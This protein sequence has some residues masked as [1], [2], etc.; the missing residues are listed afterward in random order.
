[1]VRFA[2]EIPE[3]LNKEFRIR[4]IQIYGSKKGV[5][6]KAVIEA[7]QMWIKEKKLLTKKI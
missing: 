6:T 5:I 7:I 2:V 4:V 3:N 1:M